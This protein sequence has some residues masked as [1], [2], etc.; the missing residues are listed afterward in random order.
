MLKLRKS[1]KRV[2]LENFFIE[3]RDPIFGLIVLIGVFFLIAFFSYIWGILG[4]KDDKKKIQNFIKKFESTPGLN[5]EHKKLLFDIDLDAHSFAVLAQTFAK[6]G[7]FEKAIVIYLVAIEKNSKKQEK[8]ELLVEL[9]KVYFKA[10]FLQR[11]EDVFLDTLKLKPRNQEALTYLML[12]YESFKKFDKA[13]EV[14]DALEEQGANVDK[15]KIYIQ[16]NEIIAQ[17]IPLEEKIEKILNFDD[18]SEISKRACMELL[19]KNGKKLSEFKNLPSIDGVIDI[20]WHDNEIVN[21]QD[22][23]YKALYFAKGMINEQAKSKFFEIN[24]VGILRQNNYNCA[25][26]SFSYMCKNC[27]NSL[28]M[29]FYRCPICHSLDG[30]NISMNITKSYNENSETF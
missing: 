1:Q 24:A 4:T 8:I 17:K 20:L 3:Y 25:D 29:H 14:L 13:M 11:A 2:N 15:N 19:L 26:I 9:G 21:L 10:G 28:P 7:S 12:I 23:E 18:E 16:I 5:D 30:V 6:S 27:K 22:E